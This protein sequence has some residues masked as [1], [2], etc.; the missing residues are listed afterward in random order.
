MMKRYFSSFKRMMKRCDDDIVDDESD[1][2]L[3]ATLKPMPSQATGL[4]KLLHLD[5]AH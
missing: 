5:V 2:M 3:L 4:Q 1:R